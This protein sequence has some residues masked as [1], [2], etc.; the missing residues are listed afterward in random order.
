MGV[1]N[2]PSSARS[3]AWI[4]AGTTA[5]VF[6]LVLLRFGT[7]DRSPVRT[8]LLL[9]AVIVILIAGFR[10]GLHLLILR[11]G[12]RLKKQGMRPSSPAFTRVEP[13]R[14]SWSLTPGL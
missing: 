3:S 2:P 6:G 7:F 10:I 13:I 12:G 11:I 5:Y 14:A 4:A 1:E 8:I 9:V